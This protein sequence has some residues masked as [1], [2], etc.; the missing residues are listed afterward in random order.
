MLFHLFHLEGASLLRY[1]IYLATNYLLRWAFGD[2]QWYKALERMHTLLPQLNH[3]KREFKTTNPQSLI[4][5]R[6]H[7][8]EG[9]PAAAR[10]T[11]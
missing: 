10:R 11:F 7:M 2:K 3:M 6:K 9:L 1:Q 5:A 4:E 8:M